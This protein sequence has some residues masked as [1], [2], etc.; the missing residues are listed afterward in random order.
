M[1]SDGVPEQTGG[2][3]HGLYGATGRDDGSLQEEPDAAEDVDESW[4]H[5]TET[6]GEAS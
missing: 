2:E 5:A 1:S 4:A 3:G 6:G